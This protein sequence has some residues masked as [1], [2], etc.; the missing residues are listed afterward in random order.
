M[1]IVGLALVLAVSGVPAAGCAQQPRLLWQSPGAEVWG[2]VVTPG[3]PGP[4]PA[5]IL[6][7][8]STGWRADYLDLARAYADSGFVALILDYYARTGGA[9]IG[10]AEKL[11]KWETWRRTVQN[12][13]EY[14]RSMP[15]VDGRRI[16]LVGYSRGAFLAVSVGAS[17]PSVAAVVDF[18]GGG[19]G[20]TLPLEEEVKGLP[21]LLILHGEDDRIVPVSFAHELRDAVVAAGGQVDMRLFPGQRH[22]FNA[23]WAATYS[24][25]AAQQAFGV[26][27]AFLRARFRD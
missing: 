2:D 27:I 11:R 22:A 23:P 8:G 10:S 1:R 3:A 6:L 14:L 18:Y 16:A 17:I 24:D 15:V 20:G 25:S 19:G 13:V 12:T 26:V 7:Y 9:R 4:H 21:P 5:V